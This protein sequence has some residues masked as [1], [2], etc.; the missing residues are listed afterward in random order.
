MHRFHLNIV[1]L[2][3]HFVCPMKPNVNNN[4]WLINVSERVNVPKEYR[5]W[6]NMAKKSNRLIWPLKSLSSKKLYKYWPRNVESPQFP[7]IDWHL[8]RLEFYRGF[9]CL[10]MPISDSL[11]EI[12]HTFTQYS[13]PQATEFDDFLSFSIIKKV[14]AIKISTKSL[15]CDVILAEIEWLLCIL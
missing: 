1:I 2:T 4:E 15:H 3:W 14:W 5:Q 11:I 6:T 10:C 8:F 7:H 12:S 13:S 9:E